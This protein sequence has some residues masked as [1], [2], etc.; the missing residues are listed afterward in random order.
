[1]DFRI[2]KVFLERDFQVLV[3]TLKLLTKF[4]IN[5]YYKNFNLNMKIILKTSI[6]EKKFIYR[7]LKCNLY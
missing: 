2:V 6:M 5:Y 3:I 1:M 4:Y 7:K